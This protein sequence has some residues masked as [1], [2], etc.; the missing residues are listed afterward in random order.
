MCEKSI[1]RLF[2]ARKRTLSN[3]GRST[4]RFGEK[5]QRKTMFY[6]SRRVGKNGKEFTLYK[7]RT[8][9][10]NADQI[11]QPSTSAN[12]PRITRIGRILRKYKLDELPQII[13]VLKRDI[14]IVGPRPTL[15]E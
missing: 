10:R 5:D 1:L 9:V 12:D 6:K 3:P 2:L 8:M 4:G 14:S 15:K 13:N 11:G 7:V